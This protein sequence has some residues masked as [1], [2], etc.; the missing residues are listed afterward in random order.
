MARDYGDVYDIRNMSDDELYQ[1]IVQELQEYPNVDADWVDVAVKDGFVTLSGRV[2]TEG[3][4]QVA[5]KVLTDVIG[6]ENYA[7]ELVVDEL[8][9]GQRPEAADV[10]AMRDAAIQDQ[11]GEGA[12]DQTDTADHL[13]EDIEAESFGTHDMQKAIEGGVPYIPPDRPIAEGYGSGENH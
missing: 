13:T 11:L 3:E 5:E 9:R 2:G 10:A 1:L 7:N 12:E 6:V 8:H 4:V